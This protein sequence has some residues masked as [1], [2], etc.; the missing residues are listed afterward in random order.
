MLEPTT[1]TFHIQ[2]AIVLNEA[3]EFFVAG[4]FEFASSGYCCQWATFQFHKF[5]FRYA[6]EKFVCVSAVAEKSA[7]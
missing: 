3:L 1:C 6:L 2:V 4:C 5:S 7:G